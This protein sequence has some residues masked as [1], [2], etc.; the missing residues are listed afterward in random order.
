[1]RHQ[2]TATTVKEALDLLEA[3]QQQIESQILALHPGAD[4]LQRNA[5]K[6]GTPLRLVIDMDLTPLV[7]S[8]RERHV[9]TGQ[10]NNL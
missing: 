9:V 5:A 4:W 1:M 7:E 10:V 8:T 6:E 2:W 3:A